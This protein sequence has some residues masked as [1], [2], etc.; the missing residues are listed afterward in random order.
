MLAAKWDDLRAERRAGMWVETR[1]DLRA[2]KK[3]GM[4]VA[5]KV[6]SKAEKWAE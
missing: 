1:A 4:W 2:A 5:K 3:V 6:G